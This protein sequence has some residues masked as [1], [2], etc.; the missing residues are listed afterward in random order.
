[1]IP[2]VTYVLDNGNHNWLIYSCALLLRSR[3]EKERSRTVER[4][5]LQLQALVDQINDKEP[6]FVDR[7]RWFYTTP[8]P[9]ILEL[10]R[11]LGRS[12]MELGMLESARELF[13]SLRMYD[14]VI[15]CLIVVEKEGSATRLIFEQLEA[16]SRVAL[17]RKAK[18][19]CI[20][21]DLRQGDVKPL[22]D[23]LITNYSK[24]IHD[25]PIDYYLAAWEISGNRFSRAMRSIGN[26]YYKQEKY[27]EA[28]AA[29][30]K[31]LSITPLYPMTWFMMGCAAMQIE[32]WDKS[33]EAFT[34]VVQQEP[35]DTE[36]WNN[37][38]TI[39]LRN[40]DFAKAHS[41]LQRSLKNNIN[42]WRVWSNFL[43]TS[44]HTKDLSNA[45]YALAR[46]V[47]L[48]G[49]KDIDVNVLFE[50]CQH[51]YDE[52]VR[53]ANIQGLKIQIQQCFDGITEKIANNPKIWE[54][55]SFYYDLLSQLSLKKYEQNK[56][57][58]DLLEAN[59]YIEVMIHKKQS[60]LR[61]CQISGWE[62]DKGKFLNV[63]HAAYYLAVGQEKAGDALEYLSQVTRSDGKIPKKQKLI[64]A[65]M[66]LK[67]IWKRTM[68]QFSTL[69][70]WIK[71]KNK[72]DEIEAKIKSL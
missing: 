63:V 36:S 42:S 1:M 61:S 37:L 25:T 14:E 65:S 34:R 39:F 69:P 60:M 55:Y 2:Y 17:Q 52:A 22:Q 44:L 28:V 12:Y 5:C 35:E 27:K 20:M 30:E 66:M 54:A 71:L 29:F 45:I 57:V 56:N 46:M 62:K 48:K 8:Y 64:A 58:E 7:Y 68:E 19:L 31:S 67:P 6:S 11:E 51:L 38:A 3:L 10:Q 72:C 41:A 21:G 32:E 13:E 24:W 18:L 47:S 9:S 53:G 70:E 49:D 23:D 33:A 4:S 59:A 26:F 16:S 15:S 40:N 43:Y 50:F